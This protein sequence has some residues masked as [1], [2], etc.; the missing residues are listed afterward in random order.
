M[1]ASADGMRVSAQTKQLNGN[2][3]KKKPQTQRWAQTRAPVG[4]RPLAPA[5]S[6]YRVTAPNP[7]R[8]ETICQGV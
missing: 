8:T 3:A 6:R 4:S 1:P 5:S 7:I 2:A